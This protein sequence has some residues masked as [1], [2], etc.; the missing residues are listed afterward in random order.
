MILNFVKS[1]AFNESF[2]SFQLSYKV[3]Q[4]KCLFPE[5][6]LAIKW[7]CNHQ[8]VD[9]RAE[10]LSDKVFVHEALFIKLRRW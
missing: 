5:F 3:N 1:G 7:D 8:I 2:M 10:D 6:D 9:H 4:S